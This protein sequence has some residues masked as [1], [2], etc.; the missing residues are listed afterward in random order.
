MTT[1]DAK[2]P[3]V[4]PRSGPL[5]AG[6]AV[7]WL[8]SAAM[9]GR[10]QVSP[11]EIVNP[12]LKAAEAQYFP[13]LKQLSQSIARTKFPF[14]FFLS[15]YV[16]LDPAKQAEADS[17]GLE[18]V[19]FHDR[20]VLKVTGNY[21]AAYNAD[22]VTQ[23]ERAS[24][25]FHEV[26]VPIMSLVRDQFPQDAACDAIGFEIS[27]HSRTGTRNY[28][29]EGKEILVV[30]F[31]K[32]DAFA[33]SQTADDSDRQEILNRSEVYLNGAE[34][35]LSLSGPAPLNVE[36]LARPSSR[37]TSDHPVTQVTGHATSDRQINSSLLFGRRTP[38]LA[39]TTVSDSSSASQSAP[40]KLE[41]ESDSAAASGAMTQADA[42]KLQA[43]YQ[44]Q[45]DALG[46]EGAARFHLVDYAAP[47]FVL[48]Q[49][50]IALQITLRNPSQFDPEK[51]SIY[52]RAARSFDLFLAPQLKDL[53]EK[54]PTKAE[55][56]T[57]DFTIVNQLAA[58]PQPSSE[59]AEFIIPLK[60]LRKFVEAEI[61]N[62]QVVD[63]SIVLVNGV[64]I[65]LN[66]QL[67]E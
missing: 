64:R 10:T 59:A 66:L 37:K 12:E 15:R 32:R 26:I 39:A 44:P 55:F 61:T 13:Q 56:S 5:A 3:L 54:A 6:L 14:S 22:R 58:E 21:N 67:V 57:F 24:R 45:L 28:D 23:N 27:F 20:I 25:T 36:G 16:G 9:P 47:S 35:G 31:E 52:K 60:V 65:A 50:R 41:P 1:K 49:N 4:S 38:S 17:R 7:V 11:A 19:R 43:L 42:D 62:Q 30:V 29:Y 48:F 2:P 53:L 33:F 40:I 18:F 63:Q 46:K 34:Y 8:L 51:S